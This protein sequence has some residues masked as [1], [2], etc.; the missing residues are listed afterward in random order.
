MLGTPQS[1]G[2]YSRTAHVDQQTGVYALQASLLS[3]CC[4]GKLKVLLV[5]IDI[6]LVLFVRAVGHPA[7]GWNTRGAS[8]PYVRKNGL[9]HNMIYLYNKK[10]QCRINGSSL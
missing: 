7:G 10:I 5:R 9:L 8:R 3:V 2:L 4:G 1:L 6:R